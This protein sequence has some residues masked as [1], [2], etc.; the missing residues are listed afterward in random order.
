MAS[1]HPEIQNTEWKVEIG[2]QI[3]YLISEYDDHTNL[4]CD[5]SI[6]DDSKF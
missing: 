6:Q 1:V 2:D 4:D 3:T 5:V